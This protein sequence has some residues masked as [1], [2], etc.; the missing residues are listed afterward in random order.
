MAPATVR[1]LQEARSNNQ[2]RSA[3]TFSSELVLFLEKS[4]LASLHC[5]LLLSCLALGSSSSISNCGSSSGSRPRGLSALLSLHSLHHYLDHSHGFKCH[6]AL[7]AIK[8]PSPAQFSYRATTYRYSPWTFY[9]HRK[10]YY[11]FPYPEFAPS[12]PAQW[13]DPPKPG[14]CPDTFP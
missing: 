3:K 13:M 5:T 8:F 7:A 12:F 9:R 2:D 4:F 6:C 10:N 11:S 1:P 14:C